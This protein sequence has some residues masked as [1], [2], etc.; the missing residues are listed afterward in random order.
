MGVTKVDINEKLIMKNVWSLHI[1]HIKT[2]SSVAAICNV[3]L[4]YSLY[5]FTLMLIIYSLIIFKLVILNNSKRAIP[6]P[7][8]H[9]KA[10]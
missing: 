10:L 9:L 6:L 5:S 4:S 8:S 1:R 7:C 3:L 2:Y